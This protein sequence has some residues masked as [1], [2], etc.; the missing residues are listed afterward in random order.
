MSL[1]PIA[2]MLLAATVATGPATSAAAD[3]LGGLI[4]GGIIGGLIVNEANKN[5][6]RQR[7]TVQRSTRSTAST[8][9]RTA[10]R[11]VQTA[12]NYFSFPVGTPDGAIGPKSRAAISEYQAMLNFPA[13]GQLTQFERDILV[14]SYHRAQAGGANT[15]QE[16][17][18][19]PRGVRGLLVAY[20]EQIVGGS[21]GYASAGY[22]GLPPEV[23]QAVEEIARNSNLQVDQLVQRSGFIQLADLNEDGRTDYLLDTSVTGSAFWCNAQSCAV[24][25]FAST[26]EGYRRNDLQA[27]N[28]TP[29]MFDC[30]GGSCFK[31]DGQT[32]TMAALPTSPALPPAT[33]AALPVPSATPVVTNPAGTAAA[34]ALPSFLGG[35]VTAASLTSHCTKVSLLTNTNGGYVTAATMSDPAFAL[36]EQLCLARAYS[37]TQSDDLTAAI[38]GFTPDQIS[39]QCAG[40]GPVLKEHVA[41]L[42]LK[43]RDAVMQGVTAF[44][45]STGMAPDQLAG[46]AQICLG[47]GYAKDDMDV[48]V[49]SALVLT[50]LGNKG[51][52]ELPGHHLAQGF[53]AAK[54]P[55]LALP[56]YEMSLDATANG[57]AMVFAPGMADRPALIRKAA[58]T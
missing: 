21:H 50:A 3:T 58:F 36:S 17:A 44:V 22:G 34:P 35:A 12:L 39:A 47:V 46:T 7:S 49:G 20:K 9:Q 40:F 55:D 48:A 32:T 37:I 56:W 8:G 52:A 24:R 26:P 31:I 14:G 53:G 25:V 33:S 30:T 45:L 11:E 16:I 51:Y 6:N 2:A 1:K 28:A 29:A 13:T 42:S 43:D 10:N 23:S 57:A 27:F 15:M 38:P 41:A 5:K 54:R 19:N 18:R 4:A